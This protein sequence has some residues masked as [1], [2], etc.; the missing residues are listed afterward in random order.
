M[1]ES[2]GNATVYEIIDKVTGEVFPVSHDGSGDL[3][4]DGDADF[5]CKKEDG[6][7]VVFARNGSN[8]QGGAIFT[9]E[10]YVIR[11]V[12]THKALNG[13]DDVADVV[14]ASGVATA[15]AVADESSE[16]EA[17]A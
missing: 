12:E 16:E 11:D 14:P 3:D 2:T 17:T 5:F 8:E 15:E 1:N 9:N 10:Q 6:T 4:N 7:E 13:Q